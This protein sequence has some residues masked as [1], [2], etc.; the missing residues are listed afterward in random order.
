MAQSKATKKFERNHLKDTIKKRKDSAK[1]KQR[2]AVNAKKKARRAADTRGGAEEEESAN[3]AR[4]RKQIKDAKDAADFENMNMDDFFQSGLELESTTDKSS[5]GKKRKR[6]DEN[7]TT[8][9]TPQSD[10]EAGSDSEDE[11]DLEGHKDQLKGLAEKDPDFYKYLEEN[12]PELLDLEQADFNDLELSADEEEDE[13]TSRKKPKGEELVVDSGEVSKALLKKWEKSLVEQHS[14]RASRE[15]VLAFRAAAHSADEEDK[16]FKYSVSSP[17]V[18]HELL[19]LALSRVP[20]VLQHHLPVKESASGKIRLSTESKKFSTLSPLIKSYLS[21]LVYLLGYLTDALTLRLTLTSI[22]TLLPY[23]LS[24]KKL[25]RD[26]TK[27]VVNIWATSSFADSSRL[28]A[29]LVLRKLI[30]I[31]DPSIRE[32]VLKA[33][34][35]G[36]VKGARNTTVHTLSG[37][38]LMK[39]SAAELWGLDSGIG[40]TSGFNFIR[41]LAV[42]LRSTI[43]NNSNDSY[44]LVYNWQYVHSLDFWSRVLSM[45]CDSLTEAKKGQTSPLRP[46]IYPVVQVTLGALRLIPTAA[47]FPLRFHLTRSLLR[48]SSATGTYIPM[49]A[50]MHEVLQSGEMRKPP[51]GSSL[52]ALDFAVTIR[53]AKSYLGTRVYQDGIGEQ[54]QEL[55]GEFFVLWAK[56]VA[57]P[58]LSLPVIIL[59]KRWLKEIGPHSK[60]PNQ[61]SKV[62]GMIGLLV[63]KLDANCKWVEEKRAKVEF[64][65]NNRSGVEGFLREVEWDKTPLGAFVKGQRRVRDE[66]A[67]V[68]EQARK[69]EEK[70]RMEERN[71]GNEKGGDE[72]DASDDALEEDDE[73]KTMDDD[74]E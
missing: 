45:H 62:S 43:T 55:L 33:I 2:H 25:V 60:H 68:M 37:I 47:Y 29:F 8:V 53:A 27:S 66:R 67:K 49:A 14:L 26:L 15:V 46:L 17:E 18:Y 61:N 57:F 41:Q 64:A 10:S 36:F 58:E 22:E 13:S 51:K 59:L 19:V 28:A 40:Y 48:I 50:T 30:V 44:K 73:D 39:N 5:K 35:Q 38:N 71:G 52:K 4:S 69:E 34:Y 9:V 6:G 56:N 7:G 42:H 32:N 72:E 24:F 16:S 74:S 21:S 1:I 65:P 31:G 23:T 70:S 63:Q 11:Q 12:D 54:V 3:G 20:E